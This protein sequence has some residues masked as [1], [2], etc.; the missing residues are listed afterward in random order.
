MSSGHT[1][2]APD[3]GWP[4]ITELAIELWG[5]PNKP[6]SSRD[7]IRFGAKGSKSVKPSANT[8]H[9]H[10]SGEGGGYVDLCIKAR[11]GLPPRRSGNGSVPPWQDI[12]TIYPYHDDAGELILEVVRTLSGSPRFRQ[13]KPLGGDRWKWSVKDIPGHDSLLYRLPGLRASGDEIVWITEGEKDA[14]R[15]HGEGL[16]ATCNIGGAGKWR[17][18]YARE[19]SGKHCVVL[20]DNDQAGRDHAA[21]VARSLVGI[22]A[23]VKVLLLP[24]LPE[25]GDVSDWL[26]RDGNTVEE[27][28]RL[29][30]ETPDV[31]DQ[32]Q[33]EPPEWDDEVPPV[34]DKPNRANAPQEADDVDFRPPEFTDEAL[35]LRFAARHKDNL[36]YVSVWGR[37]LIREPTVWRFDDTMKSFD[38]A[39]A[40]CRQA[41]SEC[42]HRKIG[43]VLAS[44]KTV[45]AVERLAK[46]DRRH[47]ATVAQWDA[48]PW[49]LNTPGGVVDLR[50]GEMSPHRP[51]DYMTKITAVAPGGD[52][53]MWHKFLNTITSDNAELKAFI[54]RVLGYCLTGITKEHAMFF[55]Y[56]TGA[57]GKGTLLNTIAGIMGDY[58][59][60]AGME[61]FT[62]SSTDRHPT[63]LAMLRGA[64]LVIASET[65]EGRR[66]AESRI[67]A[68]TGGDPIT[69]RFMRQDFFTYLPQFKL[70]I[71]GNHKPGLRNV[72]EAMRRRLNLVPFDVKIPVPDRDKDLPEKLKAEW[73]AI[74]AWAIDGCL[75]WQKQ[76]LAPPT[77]V[78][79]ATDEYLEAEDAVGQ[80]IGECCI[81][82]KTAYATSAALFA[83]WKAWA[84]R[85]GEFVPSQKRFSQNLQG[86]GFTPERDALTRAGFRGIGMKPT[87]PP[88]DLW[89][90][91]D[92]PERV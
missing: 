84:E 75:E 43:A 8:F 64:R 78:S 89:G 13:R 55:G 58:A 10:E 31:S 88:D 92:P 42:N 85:A 48:T 23:S 14:D 80:W 4:T 35:A 44:A 11:G 1:S 70:F 49:L 32:G 77:I 62:A 27:L 59:T 87:E 53:P 72:D 38:L 24:G 12:A 16:I 50:T 28:Q 66:W 33:A 7:D 47:A 83:S 56:G 29:A 71:A 67:K 5:Q 45:A 82:G 51:E 65:E 54:Q 81:T 9:D 18:V 74:L 68:L 3:P 69:A 46:A 26:D 79:A 57:N 91:G 2:F 37:W 22:A 61:T 40:I 30:R 39:R 41:A 19:F 73:P 52:C 86:R 21:T 17:D 76:G 36:R 90:E 15:M 60:V 25:K 6:L 20:Q 34:G 63:D